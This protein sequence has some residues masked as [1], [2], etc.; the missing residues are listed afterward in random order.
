LDVRLRIGDATAALRQHHAAPTQI[1][2]HA[3]MRT[4]EVQNW[5]PH[6][7]KFVSSVETD[8]LWS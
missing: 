8:A 2:N 7:A 6:A 5:G 4:F 1:A 3:R